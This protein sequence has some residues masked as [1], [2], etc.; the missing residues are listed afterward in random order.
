M[1][2]HALFAAALLL[3]VAGLPT[4]SSA[5]SFSPFEAIDAKIYKNPYKYSRG[6]RKQKV[7]GASQAKGSKSGAKAPKGIAKI[8]EDAIRSS[9]AGLAPLR[10]YSTNYGKLVSAVTSYWRNNVTNPN[11]SALANTILRHVMPTYRPY[12][13]DKV[14]AGA[15]QGVAN[16]KAALRKA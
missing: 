1:K 11:A 12:A 6:M 15:A 10:K 14:R 3:V 9:V 2:I 7:G 16:V 8:R 13:E 5:A 4:H